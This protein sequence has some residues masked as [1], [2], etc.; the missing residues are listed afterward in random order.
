MTYYTENEKKTFKL[1]QLMSAPPSHSP[2]VPSFG[3]WSTKP[4]K[5][6]HEARILLRSSVL[7]KGAMSLHLVK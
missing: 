7:L 5:P 1:S 2:F 4:H 3:M 6:I